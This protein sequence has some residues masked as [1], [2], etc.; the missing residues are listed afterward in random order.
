MLLVCNEPAEHYEIWSCSELDKTLSGRL[1][2]HHATFDGNLLGCWEQD[3][4]IEKDSAVCLLAIPREAMKVV[5]ALHEY[6]WIGFEAPDCQSDGQL[7]GQL[8]GQLENRY[9]LVDICDYQNLKLQNG[10]V[11]LVRSTWDGT[12]LTVVLRADTYVMSVHLQVPDAKVSFSD[13]DFDLDPGREKTVA[14]RFAQAKGL[15]D[16]VQVGQ[17]AG[18]EETVLCIEGRNVHRVVHPLCRLLQNE[19]GR[20]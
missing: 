8:D 19:A 13:N 3:A 10:K 5:D 2:V 14:V 17:A 6:L 7:V 16:A 1:M 9:F 18:L 11:Q 12:V 4:T 20:S 15:E